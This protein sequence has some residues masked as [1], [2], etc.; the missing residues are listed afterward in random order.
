MKPRVIL[1]DGKMKADEYMMQVIH[2]LNMYVT[3]LNQF[4]NHVI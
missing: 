4:I 2:L 3:S 1:H